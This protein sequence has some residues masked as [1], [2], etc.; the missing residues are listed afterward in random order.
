MYN[1]KVLEHDVILCLVIASEIDGTNMEIEVPPQ[2]LVSGVSIETLTQ[3]Y[4]AIDSKYGEEVNNSI[5]TGNISYADGL[6]QKKQW[7]NE[8]IQA[9]ITQLNEQDTT[10]EG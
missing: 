3:Y 2:I 1:V 6:L 7:L 5:S 8:L 9:K 10:E 4:N